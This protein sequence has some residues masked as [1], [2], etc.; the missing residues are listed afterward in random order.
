MTINLYYHR[1][2]NIE[3]AYAQK[4]QDCQGRNHSKII[5]NYNK[6]S[7]NVLNNKYLIKHNDNKLKF[8]VN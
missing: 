1:S 5:Y 8:I 4:D 6:N 7:Y 2:K 3:G